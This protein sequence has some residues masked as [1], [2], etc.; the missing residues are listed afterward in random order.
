MRR[1]NHGTITTLS[2]FKI[3]PLNGFNPILAKQRLHKR[4]KRVCKN[5][6][7]HHTSQKLFIQ[8][9]HWSLENLNVQDLL[10]DGRTPYERWFGEPFKG[11]IIPFGAMVEISPDFSTRSI[12]TSP[13]WQESCASH[14]SWECI[15]RRGNLERRYSDCGFGR[16]GKVGRIRNLSS[17]NQRERSI[18]FTKRRYPTFPA[19]DGTAKLSGWHYDFL[20]S[21]LRRE[22]T[23]RSEDCSGELQGEPGES[24]PTEWT[25]DAEARA[26]LWSTQGDFIYRHRNEPRVYLYVS[27]EEA[28]PIPLK[29]IDVARSTSTDLDVMQGKRVDDYWNV[30]SNRRQSG[31]WRGF[32]KLTLMKEILT[33][34]NMWSWGE[35]DKSSNDYLTRSWVARSMYKHWWSRSESRRTRMGK[36]A[37]KTR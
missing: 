15:D 21:T 35:L 33:K 11:P 7:S 1:V 4:R 19:A 27:K 37:A 22:Q 2:L 3:L 14:I 24:Q 23:V 34:G 25:D 8:T 36:R 18:D 29:Y 28:F 31:S 32:T 26:D 9:I 13:I 17:K 12:K 5:S 30:D 10:S 20:E 16:F 6:W